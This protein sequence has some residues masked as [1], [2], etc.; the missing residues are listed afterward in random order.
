MPSVFLS[1]ASK[2]KPFVEKLAQS[3]KKIGINVWFDKW[4]IDVGD[5]ITW[6]VEE[7]IRK[8]SF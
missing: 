6:K 4:E 1:H 5:S 7:G 2:D 3:L 8:M